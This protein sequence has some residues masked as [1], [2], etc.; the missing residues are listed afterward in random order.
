MAKQSKVV[1]DQ[2]GLKVIQEALKKMS[3][4]GYHIQIGIFGGKT[5]RKNG[6]MTNA[7]IGFVHEMGSISRNVPRRSFL[8]DTLSTKGKEIME[9]LK[10]ATETLFKTGKINEYLEVVGHACTN[11]VDEAFA[12][13]GFGKW[14]PLSYG[15]L[16]RKAK[17]N[18]FKRMQQVAQDLYEGGNNIAIL[19]KSGQL[20]RA[21]SYR[22][23]GGGAS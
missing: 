2:T 8:W 19:I 5:S 10:P 13:G 6:E 18:D 9:S 15:T 16:M 20:R 23:V 22:V 21:I 1:F 4:G 11:M 3:D 17:G 12:T 7:E 14:A